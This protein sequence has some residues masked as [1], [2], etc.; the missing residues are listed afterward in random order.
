M[1][2]IKPCS[3]CEQKKPGKFATLYWA[4][5]S[6]TGERTA[7]RQRLCHECLVESFGSLLSNTNS[8]STDKPICP[9]CGGTSEAD[10]DPVYLTLY[11]PKMDPREFELATCAACA[12]SLLG[13]TQTGSEPL[14]DRRMGLGAPSPQSPSVWADLP[15]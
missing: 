13:L 5:F 10:L 3:L 9:A 1:G 4:H 11:P 6:G 7:W 12:A 14:V 2:W 8:A 15:F